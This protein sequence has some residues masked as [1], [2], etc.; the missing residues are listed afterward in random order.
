MPEASK[1]GLVLPVSVPG[2]GSAG[3]TG[4]W[5]TARPVVNYDK[6]T[7]CLLC[8]LFCP[9]SVIDRVVVDGRER[10]VIDYE[11]C[12]GCGVCVDVCP[13][14]AIEMVGER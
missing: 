12:K 2:Y 9:D 11:Y 3:K 7:D 6:C 8:W 5:R 1:V 4:T 14:K 13:V 10:V